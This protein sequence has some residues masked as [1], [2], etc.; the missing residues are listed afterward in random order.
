M[1]A[2]DV[3][4]QPTLAEFAPRWMQ[5]YVLTNNKPSEQR[6][7]ESALR[8]HII[9][10]LGKMRL[11]EIRTENI[12][13]FKSRLWS[14]NLSAK[15]INNV[16]GILRNLL[17]TAAEWQIVTAA[18]RVKMLP[19]TPPP[20]KT[21]TSGEVARL[22]ENA[23]EEWRLMLLLA[24]RTGMRAGELLGLHWQ[25]VDLARGIITVRHSLVNGILGTPK[26]HKTR[27]IPMTPQTRSELAAAR[28]DSGYVFQ[29]KDGTPLHH[30]TIRDALERQCR[31]AGVPRVG[32]HALRHTFATELAAK[33]V[34]LH[35]VQSLLGHSSITTTMRYAHVAPSA[36]ED[37]VRLLEDLHEAPSRPA[38]ATG[39]QPANLRRRARTSGAEHNWLDQDKN[40]PRE[41]GD[42]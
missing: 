41:G 27:H 32:W 1:T 17:I 14:G 10:S 11:G 19:F 6:R 16:V 35:V 18:P 28:R 37:A 39:G 22:L 4:R 26:S 15:T 34:P 25:S 21:L 23:D 5:N 30:S 29:A 12:E 42:S 36:R 13:R 2:T 38:W 24:L 7:R 9:P 33:G 8:V 40:H 31:R 20:F 3:P